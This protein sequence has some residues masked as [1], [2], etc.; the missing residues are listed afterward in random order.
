MTPLSLPLNRFESRAPPSSGQRTALSGDNNPNPPHTMKPNLNSQSQSPLTVPQPS[1]VV[2]NPSLIPTVLSVREQLGRAASAVP[3]SAPKPT[4]TSGPSQVGRPGGF[5]QSTLD[6]GLNRGRHR[7]ELAS[8]L[9]NSDRP[10]PS[11]STGQRVSTGTPHDETRPRKD[12][13][14]QEPA[15]PFPSRPPTRQGDVGPETG[16]VT[17]QVGRPTMPIPLAV[18]DLFTGVC[19]ALLFSHK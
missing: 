2:S 6:V 9:D 13:K 14:P 5:E 3:Q 12:G 7:P 10:G 17:S 19:E 11:N 16:R 8:A 15:L 1:G 18:G 4:S